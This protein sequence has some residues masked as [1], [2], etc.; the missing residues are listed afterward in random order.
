MEK[1]AIIR[2]DFFKSSLILGLGGLG[3]AGGAAALP[4]GSPGAG[5][6]ISPGTPGITKNTLQVDVVVAGGGMSGVCAALAAAR[7]GASTVLVQDRPVLGGNSSSEVRMHIRGADVN[8]RP[9]ARETGILEEL[10]LENQVRNPQ[11]SAAMWDLILWERV[12][13]QENLT[14]LLNTVLTACRKEKQIIRSVDCC[15]MTTEKIF[16]IEGK[17]FIDCTGDGTLGHLAGNPYRVG[18]EARGEFDESLAPEKALAYTMGSSLLFQA[19]DLGRPVKFTPPEWAYNYPTDK[20]LTRY[21]SRYE[22]G[23]WWIEWGG[24]LDTIKD[25]D[26]IREELLKILFGVWDHIK[27]HGD[28]GANNWALEWFGML[29]A[30]RE[31][32]RLMGKYILRQD[33]LTSGRTFPDEAAYG[34]WPI[35]HHHHMGFDYKQDDFFFSHKLDK[36]YSIPLSSLYSSVVKNLFFA[37][38]NMSATHVAMSSTRVMA[39]CA[40]MGQGAG[41][42][43]AR[44]CARD[45]NPG[46][47]SP[48]DISA[49]KQ[50]ILKQDGFLIGTP[51]RDPADL[52]RQAK[53][54]A[55]SSLTGFE[56]AKVVDGVSR[57]VGTESHHWRS[58]SLDPAASWLELDFGQ[59]VACSD[60]HLTFDTNLTRSMTLTHEDRFNAAMVEG[61]QPETVK[62]YRI[63]FFHDGA[64]KLLRR[65]SGNYQ[66]KRVHSFGGQRLSKIRLAIEATNG[67]PEAR[68]FEVR[69]YG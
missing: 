43:A 32:R 36:L 67:V 31:S 17:I 1:S 7:G 57:T 6:D 16:T 26:R 48:S 41:A 2:R 54:S 29:P 12:H 47:L 13:Y 21:H 4:A 66:R 52:A 61:P 38:R 24:M 49:I 20:E 11:R 27:N 28:H 42:A 3:A 30:R 15:Q 22:Y 68:V 19:R 46:E 63:E 58:V 65:V 35:D 33:D 39:T 56:A 62:N 40:V 44:C 14:L 55:G 8:G 69:C 25:D 23:Y 18:Q 60:L 51:N 53:I 59:A 64:W 45:C 5:A 50:T 34:G 9:D 37:G 10:Q